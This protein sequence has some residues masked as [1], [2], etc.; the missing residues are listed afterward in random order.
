MAWPFTPELAE[1][2]GFSDELQ[3]KLARERR[4]K[5]T[6]DIE[7]DGPLVKLTVVHD[8]FE[9]DST[10]IQMVSEGWPRVLSDLKTMLETGETLPAAAD[11]P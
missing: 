2:F 8:D 3:T 9:L 1:H 5:V 10:A 4:S 6:F 11:T 7:Q